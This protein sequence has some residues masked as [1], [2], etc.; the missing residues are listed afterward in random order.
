MSNRTNGPTITDLPLRQVYYF[1]DNAIGD[2]P[3]G[4]KVYGML[5]SYDDMRFTK[6]WEEMELSINDRRTTPLSRNYQPLEGGIQAPSDMMR[7][8]KFATRQSSLWQ[9][10]CSRDNS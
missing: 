4:E 7:M 1:G 2:I 8:L 10:Q 9:P 5:V 6:F 3:E